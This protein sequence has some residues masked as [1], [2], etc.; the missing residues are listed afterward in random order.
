MG[1]VANFRPLG[2]L[3]ALT[4]SL[5]WVKTGSAAVLAERSDFSRCGTFAAKTGAGFAD[6]A[7]AHG[8]KYADRVRV[9][10]VQGSGK[11]QL[12]IQLR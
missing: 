2:W 4:I 3:L 7:F 10:G 11:P 1:E 5:T 6:D 9:R 12:P 8:M